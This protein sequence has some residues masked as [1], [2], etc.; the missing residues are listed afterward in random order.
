MDEVRFAFEA[1]AS[2]QD[3][4]SFPTRLRRI[5]T[6]RD[7]FIPVT[8]ARILDHKKNLVKLKGGEYVAV[9]AIVCTNNDAVEKWAGASVKF[10][11][12][13]GIGGEARGLSGSCQIDA[14]G[15]EAGLGSRVWSWAS[16]A[17][18]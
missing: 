6:R 11:L 4:T 8:L 1:H 10:F 7:I 9:E 15:I 2:L 12:Y 3:T 18:P 17:A 5:L 13:Q 16:R 14:V